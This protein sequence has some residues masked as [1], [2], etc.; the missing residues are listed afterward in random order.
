MEKEALF[1]I[2]KQFK[3]E[4][5]PSNIK[6]I[7]SG[8][9]NETYELDCMQKDG[10]D[11]AYILQKVNTQVFPNLN[12]VMGNMK[13]VTDYMKQNNPDAIVAGVIDTRNN[14]NPPVLENGWRMLEFISNTTSY[15]TTREIEVL[16]E[17]GKAVGRFQK[18][19]EGFH[20][21]EL[22]ET[23]EKFHDTRVR[24][25]QLKQ[26]L[27]NKQNQELRK[28]RFQIAKKEIDFVLEHKA[29]VG[30]IIEKIEIGEIPLRVTHN[31]TKLSNILFERNNKKAVCLI[32]FD[33]VMPGSLLYDYGEGVRTCCTLAKE[34]EE[35]LSK[36]IWEEE[37][38]KAFT[39]G[40]LQEIGEKLTR[41]EK[42]LLPEAAILMT[43]ENGMRFLTDYLNG[44]KY[45]HTNP[46]IANHNLKRAKT[47]LEL[48]KQM[49]QNK[50]KLYKM[51][52]Y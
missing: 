47:Q 15:E 52:T 29:M 32:D 1:E 24:L 39:E 35:D 30:G 16:K 49:E 37:R 19:L 25:E 20:A 34:D 41:Q 2:A 21:N 44:D 7:A 3:I 43:Y 26:A 48:V 33:T 12:A 5:M 4:G 18:Q 51:I 46:N 10:K 36:V 45:F 9:I 6:K 8:H 13:K 42:E 17:A 23:I 11:I 28:E 22:T 27:E 38:Q 14:S 50:P 31:D 40:F